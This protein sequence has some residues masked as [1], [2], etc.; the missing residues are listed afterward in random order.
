MVYYILY[1]K[2]DNPAVQQKAR[3]QV[4]KNAQ[5]AGLYTIYIRTLAVLPQCLKDLCIGD[6]T[7]G[8]IPGLF[9]LGQ[10]EKKE[11]T[12]WQEHISD[13]VFYEQLDIQ[14]RELAEFFDKHCKVTTILKQTPAGIVHQKVVKRKRVEEYNTFDKI[15]DLTKAERD[16]LAEIKQVDTLEDSLIQ[17]AIDDII[18]WNTTEQQMI[19]DELNKIWIKMC[20]HHEKGYYYMNMGAQKMAIGIVSMFI[21]DLVRVTRKAAFDTATRLQRFRAKRTR[22]L[23]DFPEERP[24]IIFNLMVDEIHKTEREHNVKLWFTSPHDFFSYWEL[25]KIEDYKLPNQSPLSKN[26]PLKPI[27]MLP[28]PKK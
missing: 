24:D 1:Y 7:S 25:T 15:R 6:V 11:L 12:Y 10:G 27:V 21:D 8:G 18:T 28:K 5:K 19:V 3:D 26:P 13:L 2:S 22:T 17:D 9:A 14:N 23:S 4:F 16:R 20:R